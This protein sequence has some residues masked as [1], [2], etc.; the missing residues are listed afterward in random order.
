MYFVNSGATASEMAKADA[1]ACNYFV[2]LTKM[3]EAYWEFFLF[4]GNS[5]RAKQADFWIA[6]ESNLA[7]AIANEKY[8]FKADK[9]MTKADRHCIENAKE[10]QRSK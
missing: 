3:Q 4:V 1:I 8:P 2:P 10:L 6:N 9:E 5:D 7:E